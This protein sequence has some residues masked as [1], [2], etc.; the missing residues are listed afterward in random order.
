MGLY[1]NI[2][3]YSESTTKVLLCILKVIFTLSVLFNFL[4]LIMKTNTENETMPKKH[5][6]LFTTLWSLNVTFTAG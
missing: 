3:S 6:K 4:I 2:T 5:Y 1:Y